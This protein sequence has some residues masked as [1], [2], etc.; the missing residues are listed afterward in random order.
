MSEQILMSLGVDD[1]ERAKQFY[2]DGLGLRIDQDHGYFVTFKREA[3]D[4]ALGAYTGRP[5]AYD[6]G[7][8]TGDAHRGVTLSCI[9]ESAERVDELMAHAENAGADVLEPA[10]TAAWG[11]YIGYFTDPFDNLWKIVVGQSG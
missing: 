8:I 5:L 10:H 4:T 3:G 7:L 1:I 6:V 9:V 2:T 11:G